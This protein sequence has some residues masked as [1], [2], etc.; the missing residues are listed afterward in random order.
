MHSLIIWTMLSNLLHN[1]IH[2]LVYFAQLLLKLWVFFWQDNWFS[3]AGSKPTMRS[4][5]GIKLKMVSTTMIYCF[6]LQNPRR[7]LPCRKLFFWY[8]SDSLWT[9][10][11]FCQ[12]QYN[13]RTWTIQ[14]LRQFQ[15]PDFNNVNNNH[16]IRVPL[17]R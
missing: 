2:C 9:N 14:R 8:T 6:Q 5:I 3:K 12:L 4:R 16:Q 15:V 11:T 7:Q 17:Y 1:L 13:W 10:S